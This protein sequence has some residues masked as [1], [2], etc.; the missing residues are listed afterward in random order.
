MDPLFA[1]LGVVILVLV[2][3]IVLLAM[4]RHKTLKKEERAWEKVQQKDVKLSEV[5]STLLKWGKVCMHITS[6][7]PP[8]YPRTLEHYL[9]KCLHHPT[10]REHL[11]TLLEL[12]KVEKA[13]RMEKEKDENPIREHTP[14]HHD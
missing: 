7:V 11:D 6:D 8:P 5:D 14:S 1:L 4:N 3:V 13:E 2:L 10:D 12:F 9:G